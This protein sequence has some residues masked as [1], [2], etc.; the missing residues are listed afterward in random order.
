M[1][2]NGL[3]DPRRKNRL[4]NR[5]RHDLHARHGAIVRVCGEPAGLQRD[6]VLVGFAEILFRSGGRN[7]IADGHDQGRETGVYSGDRGDAGDRRGEA[8]YRVHAAK[9][10][11]LKQTNKD[12]NGQAKEQTNDQK[13]KK[14]SAVRRSLFLLLLARLRLLLL[15]T[16]CFVPGFL[17][18]C[19][20]LL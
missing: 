6:S 16:F 13:Q 14:G 4:Y 18:H 17:L 9:L 2:R 15:C 11:C 5:E 1:E 19:Y 10:R 8:R 12:L 3:S 20:F 7:A